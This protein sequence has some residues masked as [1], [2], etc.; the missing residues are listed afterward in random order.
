MNINGD[1][2]KQ[3]EHLGSRWAPGGGRLEKSG[4]GGAQGLN[5]KNWPTFS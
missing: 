5:V 1:T 3:S 4:P 2:A